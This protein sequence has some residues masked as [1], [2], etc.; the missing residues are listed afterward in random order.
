MFLLFV[1]RLFVVLTVCFCLIFYMLCLSYVCLFV[2]PSHVCACVVG[3]LFIFPGRV[4]VVYCCM[5]CVV[6]VVCVR[7]CV[8]PAYLYWERA[9]FVLLYDSYAVVVV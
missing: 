9:C 1:M 6:R 7:A 3:V 4:V 5:L 8:L 2:L